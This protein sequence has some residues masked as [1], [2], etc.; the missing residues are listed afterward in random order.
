[1]NTNNYIHKYL[2]KKNTIIIII[3]IVIVLIGFSLSKNNKNSNL[4]DTIVVKK[5]ELVQKVSSTGKI[6][7]VES[8]DLAFENGGSVA[9]S[10][11]SVGDAVSRQQILVKLNNSDMYTLLLKAQADLEVEEATLSEYLKG[12]RPEEIVIYETKLINKSTELVEAGKNLENNIYDA[13]TKSDDAIRNKSDQLFSNSQSNSP[14]FSFQVSSQLKIDVEN[15][16]FN[17]GVVLSDWE[18][19]INTDNGKSDSLTVKNNLQEVKEF[20]NTLSSAVNM[21]LPTSTVT[22]A[23]IDSY[24][25]DISIARNNINSAITSLTLAEGKLT[26]AELGVLL[27]KQE[28]AL[29]KSGKTSDQILAEK[30]RVKSAKARVDNYK[31]LISKGILRSPINGVITKQDAKI[32]EIVSPGSVVVS[33]ISTKTFEIKTNIPEVDIANIKVGNNATLT[34]D[35][36]S[37]DDIFKANVYSI[38]P[39]ETVIDGVSTYEVT[40]RFE[41]GSGRVRSGMT[42][43]IEIL[44]SVTK[45]IISVPSRAI[46][47]NSGNKFVKVLSDNEVVVEKTISTGIR[48]YDGRVEIVEGLKEGDRVIIFEKENL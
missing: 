38:N 7:P 12:A 33:L 42:A 16:R 36:Y 40:L 6:K 47:D 8:A 1:M 17:I 35:A 31:A 4:Y 45:N 21:L 19:Y 3:S 44:T 20:L 9:Y 11:F 10:P 5:G 13:F 2:N 39:A 46:F 48:S 30:S 15:K 29:K 28:L 41:D 23:T 43:N 34:L 26:S 14:T 24:K 22:Q 32:G 27:A 25:S 18:K 37:E